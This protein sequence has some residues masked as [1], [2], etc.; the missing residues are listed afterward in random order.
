MILSRLSFPHRLLAGIMLL[1]LCSTLILGYVSGYFWKELLMPRFHA[2]L[3]SL[4]S[5]LARSCELPLLLEDKEMLSNLAQ[6]LLIEEDVVRVVILNRD[7]NALTDISLPGDS[8]GM[9]SAPVKLRPRDDE[10]AIFDET[11]QPRALGYVHVYFTTARIEDQLHRLW[12]VYFAASLLMLVTGSMVFLLL[13]RALI[14]PLRSLSDATARI[15]QGDFDI[16]VNGGTLPETKRLAESFNMMV[17]SL[18][19]SRE[20]AARSYQEMLRHRTLVE[21]SHFALTVAHE[22]KNPLGIIKGAMDVLRKPGTD[23]ATRETMISYVEDE[24]KRLNRLIQ[25]F[26]GF[27]SLSR[28]S[29]RKCN[30]NAIVSELV[31]RV[32]LEWQKGNIKI[33]ADIPDTP[34]TVMVDP[35]LLSQALLNIIR[36]GGESCD[37]HGLIEVSV[38]LHEETWQV[39]ISDN[40]SGMSRETMKKALEPFF[41]TKKDGTG[42]GLA[43]AATV[44]NAHDGSIH[45]HANAP[46]G[47]VCTVS[48]PVKRGWDAH[49]A[50]HEK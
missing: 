7:G 12:A 15:S 35:D 44:I 45:F 8:A 32:Q 29:M 48:L 27:A 9:V 13:S 18:A 47:T 33:V 40:G 5:Y 31:E 39:I 41:T 43:F 26:L 17:R 46:R 50:D 11:R 1:I 10:L 6:G 3:N 20:A 23:E 42:L 24:V 2:R 21:V 25:K 37:G 16:E 30:I 34:C 36:N 49:V 22:V 14:R 4:T 19:E 28:L 38:T